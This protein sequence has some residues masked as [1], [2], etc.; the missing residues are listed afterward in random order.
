MVVFKGCDKILSTPKMDVIIAGHIF[1]NRISDFSAAY[2]F[3]VLVCIRGQEPGFTS[4]WKVPNQGVTK[5]MTSS[6]SQMVAILEAITSNI[7]Q[8]YE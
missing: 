2:Y 4:L 6:V 7:V 8:V 3:S 5:F 1:Y